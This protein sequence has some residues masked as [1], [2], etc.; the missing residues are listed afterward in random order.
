MGVP[1]RAFADGTKVFLTRGMMR[2]AQSDEELA[3]VV[4]HETA[5]N[6]MGHIDK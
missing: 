6:I 5:H 4:A 1:T 3:L 2:F